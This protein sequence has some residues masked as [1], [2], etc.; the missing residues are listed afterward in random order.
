MNN[1][2]VSKIQSQSKD[3]EWWLTHFLIILF[4]TLKKNLAYSVIA[5]KS[6]VSL[7]IN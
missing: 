3:Y 7:V 4:K 5:Q 2:K 6:F 1:N